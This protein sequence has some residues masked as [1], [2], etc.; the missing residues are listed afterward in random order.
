MYF[1]KAVSSA[2]VIIATILAMAAP[3]MQENMEGKDVPLYEEYGDHL[4]RVSVFPAPFC[5]EKPFIFDF[6]GNEGVQCW[7]YDNAVSI[8]VSAAYQEPRP[9]PPNLTSP[10]TVPDIGT[11]VPHARTTLLPV[12]RVRVY[13][14]GRTGIGFIPYRALTAPTGTGLLRRPKLIPRCRVFPSVTST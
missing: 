12:P 13:L 14:R 1:N 2:L 4:I 11:P 7:N 3:T 8:Q 5:A 10:P 9:A 6:A